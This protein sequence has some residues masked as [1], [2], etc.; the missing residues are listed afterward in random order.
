MGQIFSGTQADTAKKLPE[1]SSGTDNPST[2]KG[3]G[4]FDFFTL[5]DG[6]MGGRST[7]KVAQ[8]SSGGIIFTGTIH[9]EGGGDYSASCRTNQD[10]KPL[11]IPPE[12]TSLVLRV[13][14]DGKQ[15]KALLSDGSGSGPYAHSPTYQH[16][17]CTSE[18]VQEIT[19][20]LDEFKPHLDFRLAS[21]QTRMDTSKMVQVGFMLSPLDSSSHANP[22]FGEG[23]FSFSLQ[24][25][26]MDFK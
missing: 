25:E 7:S 3:L 11:Q 12:A 5:H 4:G 1:E 17:F 22:K 15:Y 23:V 2:A 20:S 14:G 16:D 10:E 21:D 8:T 26:A 19:M 6:I 18:E 9:P 24:V 13:K